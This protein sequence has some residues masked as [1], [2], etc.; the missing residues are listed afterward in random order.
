MRI[1]N[2]S[3]A[4]TDI[5]ILEGIA[6]D[7][8]AKII[9][10]LHTIGPEHRGHPGASLSIA[11]IVT[12]LYF[13]VMRVDSND[14]RSVRRDRLVLSKG[15]GCL[16]VYVA[17]AR[18]GF[19]HEDNLK[20]FRA[21]GGMLQGHPD[22]RRTPGIE[23]TSGSLGNGLSAAVGMA[24]AGEYLSRSDARVFVIAGDGELQEGIVWEAAMA[25][26]KYKLGNLVAIIDC[27][28]LQGSGRVA[29]IMP[30]DP[31]AA[32]WAA[33]GWNVLEV[34]GHVM[35]DVVAVLE[36]A[37]HA[38]SRPTVVLARTIKGK[39]VAY[40]EGNNAWH[41]AW[42]PTDR[43]DA[44]EP[45]NP[46]PLPQSDGYR[47][48]RIAYGDA[49]LELAREGKE[50]VALSADSTAS[51]AV[52]IL[53]KEFPGR[54]FDVGIAEQNMVMMA[55]GLAA[56]GHSVFVSMYGVFASMRTLEQIRTFIAY[57]R[58]NVKIVAGLTGFSGG[59][60]GATHMALEDV[61]ILRSIPDLVILNPCDAKSTRAAVRAALEYQ[62][63]VYIRVGRDASAPVHPNDCVLNI[64]RGKV[65]MQEGFD[66]VLLTTG[67][68]TPE[69]LKAAEYLKR[70]KHGVTVVEFACLKPL[71]R[72][73][74]LWAGKH[75][76]GLF[77]IEE[78]SIIG[79]LGTAI[80]ELLCQEA[81]RAVHRL[82][83]PDC[84]GESGSVE[85]LRHKYGL[86]AEQI[87][88]RIASLVSL[89]P[90]RLRQQKGRKQDVRSD[91]HQ[92]AV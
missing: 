20:N 18:L 9:S 65:L 71:D 36:K 12:A 43:M 35:A 8:R 86:T 53:A 87:A 34:D 50:F 59:I 21:I 61:G 48:T 92:C 31:L 75:A 32:K 91:E 37:A 11:D 29:D 56:E 47:S 55:A 62:G 51:M 41:Q 74:I 33:F 39:G 78:H 84:F 52:N 54:C 5:E 30:L 19:F 73:L 76:G 2:T 89:S 38:S 17:L 26:A 90:P 64:G 63:P 42:P 46:L 23:M 14:P 70:E 80:M 85:Q 83:V 3:L 24:L 10:V 68:I 58:L 81:P 60:E 1:D 44:L 22:M 57:S 72:E 16:A 28:G 66:I 67:L 49:L 82:G 4:T 40:M 45:H 79:G 13:H 27:N 25:A 69:V 6:R 7:I 88:A 77:V 15:H